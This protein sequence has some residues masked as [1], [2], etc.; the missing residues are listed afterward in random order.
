MSPLERIAA[1][2]GADLAHDAVSAFESRL[3]SL[4]TKMCD[5]PNF[6][7]F[8]KQARAAFVAAIKDL[9]K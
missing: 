9:A 2:C 1:A 7:I 8:A 4:A 3:A 5:A 6:D